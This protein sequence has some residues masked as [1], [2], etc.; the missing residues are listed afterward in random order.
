[1]R[2]DLNMKRIPPHIR[3]RLR[4]K[5][6]CNV[7]LFGSLKKAGDGHTV[8]ASKRHLLSDSDSDSD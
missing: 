5:F 4:L 8:M 6:I 7:S 1:M 3:I 2:E